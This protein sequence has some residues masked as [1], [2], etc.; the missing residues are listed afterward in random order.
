VENGMV[1]FDYQGRKIVRLPAAV[2]KIM[3][4]ESES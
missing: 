2:K 4:G 1:C 3:T